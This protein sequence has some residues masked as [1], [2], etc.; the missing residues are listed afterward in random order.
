MGWQPMAARAAAA[1]APA[2]C[3]VANP[4]YCAEAAGVSVLSGGADT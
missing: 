4:A 2:A 1:P 3:R